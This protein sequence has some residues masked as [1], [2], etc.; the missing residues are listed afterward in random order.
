MQQ[1]IYVPLTKRIAEYVSPRIRRLIFALDV[2]VPFTVY[3][4]KWLSE[5]MLA[6]NNPCLWTK[7]GLRCGTCGGTHC[8][9]AFASGNW[10][11]AFAWNPIVFAGI[12]YAGISLLFINIAVFGQSKCAMKILK[13]MYSLP[14]FFVAIGMYVA[15]VILR[16]LFHV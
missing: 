13:K 2:T 8:V 12:C 7:Y 3:F 9:N 15:F 1:T 14:M 5:R 6:S 11:E 4:S 10:G 16:N